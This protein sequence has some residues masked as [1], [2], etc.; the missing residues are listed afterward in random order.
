MSDNGI[1]VDNSKFEDVS[2]FPIPNSQ[3]DLLSFLGLL[4]YFRDFIPGFASISKPL[5]E[6]RNDNDLVKHWNVRHTEAFVSLKNKLFSAPILSFPDFNKP[7]YVACDASTFAIGAMLFQCKNSET[8]PLVPKNQKYIKF[9]SSALRK[10]ELNYS[11]S[12]RELLAIVYALSKFENNLLGEHFVIFT[13]H[14][15]LTFLFSQTKLSSIHLSWADILLKFSYEIAFC[16]G[17]INTIPDF[18]SRLLPDSR[19]HV[20]A[21]PTSNIE[22][23]AAEFNNIALKLGKS[24]PSIDGR[25]EILSRLHSLSHDS[26]D[27]LYKRVWNEGLVW[28]SLRVDCNNLVGSCEACM[29]CSISKQGFHPQTSLKASLPMDHVVI[30]L[31]GPLPPSENHR[32]VLVCID[33]FTRFIF[34]KGLIEKTAKN[35]A[36]ALFDIFCLFGLPKVVSSD[37]GPE[38]SNQVVGNLLEICDSKQ[39]F[40]S[41]YHPQANGIVERAVRATLESLRRLV[42]GFTANWKSMLPL[43]QLQLNQ[44]ISSVNKSTAFSLMFSRGLI[45]LADYSHITLDEMDMEEWKKQLHLVSHTIFPAISES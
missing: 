42:L 26:A 43:A 18:L 38:F 39:R 4:N 6:L 28:P 14:K 45:K 37:N 13:D 35:T 44:R 12:K 31:V 22:G 8:S 25:A 1:S 34:L 33:V 40:S 32:Y 5:D 2:R 7:F 24:V 41:P 36:Y 17:N 30:D 20:C 29:K 23:Q 9:I 3:K 27:N 21:L 11:T 19:K 16:P 15:P 10:A